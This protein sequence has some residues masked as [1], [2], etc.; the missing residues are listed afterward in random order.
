MP[1]TTCGDFILQVS[2]SL[3][4]GVTVELVKQH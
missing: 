4:L 2:P 3:G 1:A